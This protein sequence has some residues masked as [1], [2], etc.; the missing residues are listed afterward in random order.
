MK[1]SGFWGRA[2]ELKQL[3]VLWQVNAAHLVAITG[4]RRVGKS[5]LIQEFGKQVPLCLELSGLP[6]EAHTTAQNQRDEFSRQLAKQIKLPRFQ[7]SDWGE[8]LQALADQTR[9]HPTLIL[10][11]E[12][13][14]MGSKDPLFLG[15]L[16]TVWDTAFKKHPKVMLVLCGS[17]SSWIEQNILSSTGYFGRLSL[18]I[19]LQEL[20]LEDCQGFWGKQGQQISAY[21]KFKILSV[22]GGIP[23][24]LEEIDPRQSAEENIRQLCFLDSGILF[25][26]FKY[27]FSDL[28][29][30]RAAVYQAI[31]QKLV[32]GP[33]TADEIFKSLAKTK[34][35]AISS[36][37]DDLCQSS[38]ISRDYTWHILRGE[39][40]KLSRYRLSDNYLRFYLKYIATNL[41]KIK[42]GHFK[43]QPL[44]TLPG[45]DSIMGLQFENLV[46]G[47]RS[48]LL[49]Q[50]NIPTSE[51]IFDNPYFQNATR[52]AQG[53][54][55]D[56]L[57][58]TKFNTLYGCEIK[59]SKQPIA[60]GIINEMQKKIS[61]LK[62]PKRYSV[63][64]VLVHVNGVDEA[65]VDADYFSQIVDF[66]EFLSSFPKLKL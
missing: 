62:L 42:Q 45:W 16:K 40:S 57:I 13:S 44:S 50:L 5:R 56:Y 19:H 25:D 47:N 54:Q 61:R 51:L 7:S 43:N 39:T 1:L 11:D 6:P 48:L 66:G 10:L 34:S 18:K 3:Q 27:M 33:A 28:F 55:I 12:V 9:K 36:Y 64:P 63:R 14:W 4:R 21:E 30:R 37:L 58:Q 49:Q 23:R 8:L 29:Q 24:Y 41:H 38:F 59:F 60:I 52:I 26:E 53:C 15:K 20:P 2:R 35:G 65:V 31:V 46:L 32:Q 22:T 17:V